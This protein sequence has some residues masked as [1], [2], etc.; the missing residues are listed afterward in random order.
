MSPSIVLEHLVSLHAEGRDLVVLAH[1]YGGVVAGGA[2]KGLDIVS[3]WLIAFALVDRRD[4][5]YNDREPIPELA[6][7]I[8]KH[9]ML[10]FETKPSSP[11]WK[12][13]GFDER[14]DNHWIEKSAVKWEIVHFETDH[15]PFISRPRPLA[16]QIVRFVDDVVKL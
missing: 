6:T 9:A 12:D 13:G 10:A 16:E 4:I 14:R 3:R 7:P 15:M 8:K 1:S 11:G 2:M 5:L